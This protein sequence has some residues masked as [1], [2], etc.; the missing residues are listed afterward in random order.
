MTFENPLYL[1]LI[2]FR[3]AVT[4]SFTVIPSFNKCNAVCWVFPFCWV[5]DKLVDFYLK[6]YA[7]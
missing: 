7:L 4:P 2:T 5:R 1:M 6:D 3:Q